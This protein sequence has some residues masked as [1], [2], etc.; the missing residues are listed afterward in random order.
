M[1][2]PGVGPLPPPLPEP[3]D[4]PAPLRSPTVSIATLVAANAIPLFGVIFL[5]WRVFPILLIYWVENVTV[6]AFNVL[7]MLAA[8][9]D[10]PGLWVA[11]LFLIPFFCVHFGMFT[12]VHGAFVFAVFGPHEASGGFWP[13][14][15]GVRSIIYANGLQFAVLALVMSHAVSFVWNYV[16][17]GEFR[18]VMPTELMVRPYQRVFILHF[19]IILGA[20]GTTAVGS[21]VAALVVLVAVKTAVDVA[22][23]ARE[24]ARLSGVVGDAG[25]VGQADGLLLKLL[26][27]RTGRAMDQ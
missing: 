27:K 4:A 11:K 17:G 14:A 24:R 12:A 19:V 16:M 1:S 21:P 15:D 23:H 13:S 6:G 20:I 10:N 7:R 5:G 3:E 8:R 9:P 18:R 26:A 25:V 2:E 22:A